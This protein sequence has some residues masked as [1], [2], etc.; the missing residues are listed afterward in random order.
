MIEPTRMNNALAAVN[1]VLVA[2]RAMAYEKRS[3]E[4]LAEILDVAEYLPRLLADPEDKTA[5]FRE[6]IAGLATKYPSF[7]FA[8]ERFDNPDLGRW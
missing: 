4:E 6:Q 8:V 2:T 7:T 1:A 5:E 3:H